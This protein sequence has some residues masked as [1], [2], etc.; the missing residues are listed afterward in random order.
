MGAGR[1]QSSVGSCTPQALYQRSRAQRK[2]HSLSTPRRSRPSAGPKAPRPPGSPSFSLRPLRKPSVLF[3]GPP[4]GALT[5]LSCLLQPPPLL[6][7][8]LCSRRVGPLTI[9][10]SHWAPPL[11]AATNQSRKRRARSPAPA[12]GRLGGARRVSPRT[13]LR[14]VGGAPGSEKRLRSSPGPLLRQV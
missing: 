13:Q 9:H 1:A 7:Q 8:T 2:Q 3:P 6:T 5:R 14:P 4:R 10:A 11:P 12:Y